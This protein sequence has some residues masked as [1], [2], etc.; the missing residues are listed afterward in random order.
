MAEKASA[1]R[2]GRMIA[3]PHES[4]IIERYPDQARLIGSIVAEWSQ[5]EH[6]LVM[7]LGLSM[8]ADAEI[9]R[10]MLYAI[11]SS[12]ARLDVISA[13][14]AVLMK[15]RPEVWAEM[16]AVLT[17][18]KKVLVQRNK[19]AHSFYGVSGTGELAVLGFRRGEANDLP[20]HDLKY[21]FDRVRELSKA[22]SISLAFALGL[23]KTPPLASPL[24]LASPET[25]GV[26]SDARA[27]P[28]SPMPR[29]AS[30]AT[31]RPRKKPRA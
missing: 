27:G 18:A 20:L 3:W 1:S 16:E 30:P 17:E 7:L 22:V 12:G 13:A 14:F 24:P 2:Q 25:K 23:A 31:R 19:Y 15:D 11:E 29:L 5:V 9:I 8:K 28:A 6:N 4:A 26:E 10:P 21:Q